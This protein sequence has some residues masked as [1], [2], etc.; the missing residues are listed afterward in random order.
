[1]GLIDELNPKH[2]AFAREVVK[3]HNGTQAAIRAGYSANGASV[4]ANRLLANPKIKAAVAELESKAAAK[5]QV[6]LEEVVG[7]LRRVGFS[8]AGQILDERGVCRSLNE[9]PEDIRRCISSVKFSG[10]GGTEVRFWPKTQALELLGKHLGLKDKVE[11]SGPDGGPV[12]ISIN[13]NR[14]RK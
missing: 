4:T 11:I 1:M 2:A 12:P 10:D 13:I 7:E 6:T 8:D 3:D 14:G 9:M 5:A